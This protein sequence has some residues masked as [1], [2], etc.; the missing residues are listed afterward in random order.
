[1]S[2]EKK[3]LSLKAKIALLFLV[4]V[5]LI[6]VC[7]VVIIIS[8]NTVVDAEQYDFSEKTV[9]E[10]QLPQEGEK[11]AQI[12]LD[13]MRAAEAS[14]EAKLS[15]GVNTSVSLQNFTEAD[16][17]EGADSREG[18][19]SHLSGTIAGSISGMYDTAGHDYA[20]TAG[21]TEIPDFTS[22]IT[23]AV[24]ELSEDGKTLTCKAVADTDNDEILRPLFATDDTLPEK[25]KALS[26]QECE[27]KDVA[28]ELTAL[29]IE[30]KTDT[31]TE[32]LKEY[33][34]R[35]EYDVTVK[36]A[37][38]GKVSELGEQTLN[39]TYTVTETRK[40]TYVSINIKED[41][42]SLEKG[43]FKT[44]TV[45]ANVSENAG[46][47]DYTLTFTSS[48]PDV[49]KADDNGMVEGIAE[50]KE[51]VTVTL[52]LEYLGKTY[53][54]TV[55]VRVDVPAEKVAVTPRNQTVKAGETCVFTANVKPA[56]ATVKDVIWI[57]EDES[58]C[59]VDENGT[60][61]GVKAGA[62]RIIAVTKDGHFM[63]ASEITV[64]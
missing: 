47:D 55:E 53:S 6:G 27:I 64:E 18:F 24:P 58:I 35:R 22:E 10:Y 32:R 61:T 14:D 63:S 60:V 5:V 31:A 34:V 45:S 56:K 57:S 21:I 16:A 54:D 15:S 29:N 20:E 23:E 37:F 50:S 19:L 1:M 26:T 17:G 13:S 59:T 49:V 51:P 4:P 40:F 52:T 9:V 43:G 7:S 3:K 11:T 2:K 42:V 62:T 48:N 36:L 38:S 39:Y 28:A 33:S 30:T 25:I 44:L 12:M 8:V 41:N 46:P